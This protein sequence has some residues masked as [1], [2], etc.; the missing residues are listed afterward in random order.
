MTSLPPA[1]SVLKPTLKYLQQA[2][3]VEKVRERERK[4]EERGSQSE[5]SRM[6][7][8]DASAVSGGVERVE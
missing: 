7:K 6:A 1:N 2:K 3:I 5:R 4:S 8:L